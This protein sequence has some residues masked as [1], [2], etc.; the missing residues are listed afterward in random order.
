MYGCRHRYRCRY[1]YKYR[2]RCRYRCRYRYEY[3]YRCSGG[4]PSPGDLMGHG[5]V[6]G[7]Q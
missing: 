5:G 7:S 1:R 2:Y 6:P 3:G 4:V